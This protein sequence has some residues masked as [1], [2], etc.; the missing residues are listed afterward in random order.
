MIMFSMQQPTAY[1]T[2]DTS[3]ALSGMFL[4]LIFGYLSTLLNCDIQR[5]LQ[6][7]PIVLHLFAI[8]AFF[9]LFTLIDSGNIAPIGIVWLKTIIV[10]ILFLLMT[11]S[12]WY[13][14]FPVLILLL[15]DQTL[16]KS[17]AFYRA[18]NDP[19]A[20][21]RSR[22]VDQ[23]SQIIATSIVALAIIGTLH[24]CYL[25]KLEYGANFRWS[26]FFFGVTRCKP[27]MP[28]YKRSAYTMCN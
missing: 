3:N 12:K 25:Q 24:Y 6:K 7:H 1:T 22:I 17:L 15:I 19:S 28:T 20:E 26:K 8:I 11:K 5:L 4:W 21:R 13:F 16:K 27:Y 10:Y 2:F 9:F 23:T 18:T 14:V